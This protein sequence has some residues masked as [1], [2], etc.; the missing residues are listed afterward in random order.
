MADNRSRYWFSPLSFTNF[1]E[2]YDLLVSSTPKTQQVGHETKVETG[3]E[4]RKEEERKESRG[5][6]RTNAVELYEPTAYTHGP[7]MRTRGCIFY[8]ALPYLTL[9]YLI[10]PT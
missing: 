5:T 10:N 7:G 3:K 6:G 8:M 9:P 2:S 4:G 1:W